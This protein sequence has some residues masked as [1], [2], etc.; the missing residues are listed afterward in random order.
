MGTLRIFTYP[1]EDDRLGEL[2]THC[3]TLHMNNINNIK[4]HKN[5]KF[6]ATTSVYDRSLI[7]WGKTFN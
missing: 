5:L 2:H 7:I 6:V 4:Q 1:I 3:Y